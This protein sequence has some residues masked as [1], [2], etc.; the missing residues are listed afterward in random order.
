[1]RWVPAAELD[2]AAVDGAHQGVV[3]RVR[4]S[5][6]Y[7]V[8]DLLREAAAPP[9]LLV[10]DGLEDPQNLG[11]VLRTAEAAGV[12]GVIRQQRR[13]AP[14]GAA[15]AKTSAG[16]MTHVRI[17][18]VVNIA[19]ALDELRAA[20]LWTVGLAREGGHRY[21]E[22]DLCLPVALVVGAE[23]R[24][25]RRLVRARCDWLVSIPM[26]GRVESLNVSVAA[27]IALYEALRQ[28]QGD[29]VGTP[30]KRTKGGP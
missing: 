6:A 12:D 11:A 16:A 7:R 20:G 15:V 13:A 26:R 9:L 4:Q 21:D 30:P 8:S 17:A 27:G 25:L 22:V 19:H 29:A 23:G 18:S 1:M 3:A 14:L 28:R 2:A 10:L 24:G 5:G